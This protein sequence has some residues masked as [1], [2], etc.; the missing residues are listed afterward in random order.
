MST[1]MRSATRLRSRLTAGC[2]LAAIALLIAPATASRAASDEETIGLWYAML[3]GGNAKGLGDMLADDAVIRLL[4]SGV[5]QSKAD[6]LATMDDWRAQVAGAGIRHKIVEMAG[7]VTTVLVCY[8]FAENDIQQ[9]ETFRIEG[10]AIRENT[11]ARVADSCA[12]F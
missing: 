5:D 10:G 3:V 4:D 12:G 8:D 1:D 7:K 11:Q 6:F 9:R 2:A